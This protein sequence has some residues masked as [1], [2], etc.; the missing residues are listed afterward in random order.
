MAK[1]SC[2]RVAP[3]DADGCVLDMRAFERELARQF[4]ATKECAAV[5][6]LVEY[7]PTDKGQTTNSALPDA[8]WNLSF[9]YI[10]GAEKQHWT[11]IPSPGHASLHEG[12]ETP[13]QIAKA[14]CLIVNQQRAG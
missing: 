13:A 12:A 3:Q 6:V 5:T 10:P 11:M 4:A 1:Q 2:A 9:D 14:V 7:G 8:Y